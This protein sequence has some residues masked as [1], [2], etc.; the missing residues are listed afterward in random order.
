MNDQ[1]RF[2]LVNGFCDHYWQTVLAEALA[3]LGTLDVGTEK[4]AP[5]LARG[6]GYALLIIDASAVENVPSLIDRIR[7]NWPTAR[8]VVATASP[9]WRHARDVFQ[10]GA[11]DYIR[12]SLDKAALLACVRTALAKS[13][14]TWL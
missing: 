4:D 7:D 12:K 1:A 5:Q 2:L 6:G 10:A 9:G 3:P 13:L 8:I 14:P 11:I